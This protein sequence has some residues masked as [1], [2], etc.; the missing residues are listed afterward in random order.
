MLHRFLGWLTDN[1][2]RF[3]LFASLV[4][5][6]GLV[7][8]YLSIGPAPENH[9]VIS[10]GR[11]DGAYYQYAKRYAEILTYEGVE[12]DVLSSSGSV[13]NLQRL[14]DTDSDVDLAFVQGGI[15][16]AEDAETL[17]SLASLYFEPLWFFYRTAVAGE[18]DRVIQLGG[19][20]L[21]VG[22]EGS[23][24][25]AVV[26]RLMAENGLEVTARTALSLGGGDAADALIRGEIDGAFFIAAP[27]SP[28][29]QTLFE[30]PDVRLMSFERAD[31]YAM[32]YQFLSKVEVPRGTLDLR[33]DIPP[34]D[35]KMV[36]TTANLVARKTLHPALVDLLLATAIRVHGK[37]GMFERRDQ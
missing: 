32:R 28:T 5:L 15:A 31:A 10:A 20:R 36:A 18:I 7:I 35:I 29:L 22:G 19:H 30:Q 1:S 14:R 9:V 8:A 25:Q 4:T 16:E 34:Q 13:E 23:G 12:L 26:R 33:R 17:V 11:E 37:G 21:A 24:T 3:Y 6:L 2:F 27:S